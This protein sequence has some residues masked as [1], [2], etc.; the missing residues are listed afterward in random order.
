MPLD[1]VF[2]LDKLSFQLCSF[3]DMAYVGLQCF[4]LCCEHE[5]I[6]FAV[7]FVFISLYYYTHL[8]VQLQLAKRAGWIIILFINLL[9][10]IVTAI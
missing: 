10:I 5:Y 4:Q 9:I 8:Q 3:V 6:F 1:V 2:E 7:K